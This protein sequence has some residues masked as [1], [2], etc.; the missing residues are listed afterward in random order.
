MKIKKRSKGG[1]LLAHNTFS[2]ANKTQ[3]TDSCMTDMYGK[4]D[5]SSAAKSVASLRHRPAWMQTQKNTPRKNVAED[6]IEP[7]LL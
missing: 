6:R 2:N 7:W 5:Q 3:L 4:N 1:E